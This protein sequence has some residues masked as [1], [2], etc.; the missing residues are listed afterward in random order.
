MAGE[1]RRLQ[2]FVELR[3]RIV[4]DAHAALLEHH[5][6]LGPDNLVGKQKIGH[7]VRL[8]AHERLE[9]LASDA[10]EIGGVVVA[11]ERVLLPAEVRDEIGELAL[12]MLLRALEH[13]MLEEMRDAG[14]SHRIVR[15]A[16]LVPDH[17]GDDRRAAIL[18]RDDLHAVWQREMVDLGLAAVAGGSGLRRD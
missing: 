3:R 6:A 1:E 11:R 16:V 10:L 9:M 18:D 8:E 4:L 14:L 2:R 5:L 13:Q 15:R 7:A 12:R 17:M